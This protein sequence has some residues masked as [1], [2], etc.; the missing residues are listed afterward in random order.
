MRETGLKDNRPGSRDFPMRWRVRKSCLNQK[1][2]GYGT[3]CLSSWFLGLG[4]IGN[5]GGQVGSFSTGWVRDG[6]HFLC[7]PDTCFVCLHPN[8]RKCIGLKRS[9]ALR[10]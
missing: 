7:S 4:N 5:I 10:N 9:R 8:R 2:S 6:V 3:H 1:L